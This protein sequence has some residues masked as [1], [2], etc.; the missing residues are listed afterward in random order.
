MHL[1]ADAEAILTLRCRL[2][3]EGVATA[4][5]PDAALDRSD[6]MAQA[7]AV[8]DGWHHGSGTDRDATIIVAA[9]AEFGRKGYER[10]TMRDIAAAAGL[11]P[12]AVYRRFAS[13]DD[14]FAAVMQTS[15]DERRTAWEAVVRCSSS[16]VEK[17]DALAWLNIRA[18]EHFRDELRIQ[19]GWIRESTPN[20]LQLSTTDEQR[21]DIQAI[22]DEGIE[23][24]AL[25]FDPGPVDGWT[26]FLFEALWTPEPVVRT[27]GADAA[28]VLA[29]QTL[30]RGALARS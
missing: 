4:A 27:F 2:L 25:A 6:A 16:P 12:Q 23:V 5:P 9:R 11:A 15:T 1:R 13:K 3:L 19:L 22:V 28:H 17:L 18:V 10:A 20:I 26:R 7:H 29:R 21:R 30:L 8:A 14:L 24:G